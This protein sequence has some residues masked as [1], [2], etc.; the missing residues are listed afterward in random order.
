[1][2]GTSDFIKTGKLRALAVTT[3]TR[4][5]VFLELARLGDVV[6]G[7]EAS[8]WYGMAAPKN[9]PVESINRRWAC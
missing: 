2:I 9:T 1:M 5:E 6:P 4:T 7:Y 3:R 8:Q